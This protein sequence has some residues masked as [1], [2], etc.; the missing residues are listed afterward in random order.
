MRPSQRVLVI[1][2]DI[3]LTRQY[4]KHAEGSVLAQLGDTKVVCTASATPEVPPFLKGKG[5]GWI[6]AEY[7]ML[8]RP[9]TPACA[10]RS[11]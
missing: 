10:T 3:H 2:M 5:Q 8:P 11:R 1:I 7:G 9:P 4:T 6:T